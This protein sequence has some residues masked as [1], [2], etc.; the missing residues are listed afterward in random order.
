MRTLYRPW[1]M[2]DRHAQRMTAPNRGV[3]S[4]LVAYLQLERMEIYVVAELVGQVESPLG[5]AEVQ[6]DPKRGIAANTVRRAILL[7]MG[8]S[9]VIPGKRGRLTH[10]SRDSNGAP[11]SIVRRCS[12]T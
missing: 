9:T 7:M 11:T 12:E 1:I 6:P 3:Q 10:N 8:H 2:T 4:E 5:R